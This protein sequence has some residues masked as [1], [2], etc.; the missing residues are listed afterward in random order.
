MPK[1]SESISQTALRDWDWRE[2]ISKQS[3]PEFSCRGDEQV[4]TL[5]VFLHPFSCVKETKKEFPLGN[6]RVG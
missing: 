5:P 4:P 6:H 2:G 1:L 3:L